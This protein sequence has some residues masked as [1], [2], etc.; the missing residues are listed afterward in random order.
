MKLN[1]V[2][3][4]NYKSLKEFHIGFN[5]IDQQI[6]KV[7]CRFLIGKN[8]S[9]KSVFLEAIGLVFT[10]IMQDESPGFDYN[11]EYSVNLNNQEINIKVSCENKKQIYWID[12]K[13]YDWIQEP[14]SQKVDYHPSKIIAQ[15][16]GPTNILD[17]VLLKTPEDSLLSDIYDLIN[18]DDMVNMSERIQPVL[19]KLQRLYEDSNCISIDGETALLVIITLCTFSELTNDHISNQEYCDK[20]QELFNIIDNFVPISFSITVK[21]KDIIEK[22][23]SEKGPIEREFLKLMYLSAEGGSNTFYDYESR[24]LDSQHVPSDSEDEQLFYRTCVFRFEQDNEYQSFNY[25]HKKISSEANPFSFLTSLLYAK[26][27]GLLHNFDMIFKMKNSG[28]VLSKNSFSD[29]EYLWLARLGLLLLSRYENNVLFLFDEPD[30]HSNEAW[31][32]NFISHLNDFAGASDRPFATHEAV[33]ATHSTLLLTDAIPEQIYHFVPRDGSVTEMEPISIP[34]FGT[35]RGEIIKKIFGTETSIGTFAERLLEK[36]F[37]LAEED[38]DTSL[39]EKLSQ[40]MGP[41]YH[42]FRVINRL[43][44]LDS[45]K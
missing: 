14:F 33:V 36:A 19:Q 8:G 35:N 9:G 5:E 22:I 7:P 2:Y 32:I 24:Y 29:G 43:T 6:Y 45:K 12:G 39:L 23:G 15:S 16:T 27:I 20:R 1:K 25:F 31:N 40:R 38:N 11:I 41:G 17:D 42:Y 28:I 37:I 18:M 30:V 13:E 26:R 10:R 34:T 3:I 21:E 44:E 4:K